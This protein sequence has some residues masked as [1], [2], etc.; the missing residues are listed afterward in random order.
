M[1]IGLSYILP[2]PFS[3]I[4]IPAGTVRVISE[5]LKEKT[6]ESYIPKGTSKIFQVDTF[7]MAKYPLTNAQ[8][9]Q[10][11]EMQGYH[12]RRWWIDEGWQEKERAG[13][14][15]P[16]YWQDQKWNKPNY[17]VVG[18]SWYEALAFCQWLSEL[19]GETI[20]L[21]TEQEWQRGAQGDTERE[22]AWGNANDEEIRCNWSG[23][24]DT[25]G[26]TPVTQFEGKGDSPYGLVDMTGN[27]WEWC[28]TK[29]RT[30]EN[31][32][33]GT[34]TRIL[35]GGGWVL[36]YSHELNIRVTD[37]YDVRPSTRLNYIGFRCVRPHLST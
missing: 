21:P 11:I 8:F 22:V 24:W 14:T 31:D 20:R 12:Q 34:D 35:R 10:F 25:D 37:R 16:L 18:I 27:V 30:G 17:P 4:T 29:Y 2:Q 9:A 5:D 15:E 1:D 13:W 36:L 7:E 23:L 3:W 19:S 32:L 28:L 26:T 33:K 6:W